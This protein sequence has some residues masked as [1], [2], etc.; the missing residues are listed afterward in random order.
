[1]QI[2]LMMLKP[3]HTSHNI[4]E[5]A[6]C[7]LVS[8]LTCTCSLGHSLP[9]PTCMLADA[10]EWLCREEACEMICHTVVDRCIIDV[11][12]QRAQAWGLQPCHIGESGSL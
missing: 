2:G 4:V 1:M 9:H 12:A 11:M 6:C 8:L 3:C 7:R 10:L 5:N